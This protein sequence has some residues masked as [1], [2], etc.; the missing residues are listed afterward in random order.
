[1]DTE[2]SQP[3]ME[4][5][6]GIDVS[7]LHH[8]SNKNHLKQSKSV[9]KQPEQ[10]R[11]AP[12]PSQQ[13]KPLPEAN[14]QTDTGLQKEVL[15]TPSS[16]ATPIPTQ[17]E[18]RPQP[19]QKPPEK[20]PSLLGKSSFEKAARNSTS[21]QEGKSPPKR[22][23][24]I[25]SLKPKFGSST[26]VHNNSLPKPEP[27]TNGS[28]SEP[29]TPPA[30]TT[31]FSKTSS[32][33]SEGGEEPTESLEPYVPQQ[34]K[35]GSFLSSALRRLSSSGPSAPSKL[36]TTGTVCPRQLLNVDK[37]RERCKIKG[38]EQ[39][40]LRRV[41]FSVD[42]EIAGVS[43]YVED[44]DP[45]EMPK[46]AKDKRSSARA[47]G[48]ALKNPQ[49][50]AEKKDKISDQNEAGAQYQRKG[51]VDDMLEAEV[52]GASKQQDFDE[53]YR[54][55][56]EKQDKRR[57]QALANGSTDGTKVPTGPRDPQ[58]AKNEANSKSPSDA[59][60]RAASEATKNASKPTTDPVRVYRRCCQLRDAPV[61]KRVSEQ[62][63][64]IKPVEGE[65]EGV[66]PLL[67]L[68]GSRMQLPDF[69]VLGDWLAIVPVKKLYMD[70]ANLNDE[71]LRVILAGLLATK[72]PGLNKRKRGK[73]DT[74]GRQQSEKRRPTGYIEKLSFRNNLK[75]TPEAWKHMSL[76]LNLSHTVKGLDMS[77]NPFP[78]PADAKGGVESNTQAKDIAGMLSKA[79]STRVSDSHFEE[80]ILSE[81]GLTSTQIGPVIDGII[82]CGIHRLGF[83][84]N[85]LDRE[86]L[87]HVARYVKSRKVKG[88][89]LGSNDLREDYDLI[90]DAIESDNNM[91]ALGLADCNLDTRCLQS[92]LPRLVRLG[93]FRFLDL[94]HNHDLFASN[95]TALGVLRKYMPKLPALRRIHLVDVSL[96]PAD[97]IALAEVLPEVRNLTHIS[98]QGNPQ[99]KTLA[100]ATNATQQEDAVAY[101]ASLMAAV[102]VSKVLMAVDLD[103]PKQDS[104]DVVKALAKQIVAYSLRNMDR[105]TAVDAI[106]LEDPAS[107]IPD[108]T[109]SEQDVPIPDVLLHLVGQSDSDT[110]TVDDEGRVG[111]D[112]DYLIGGTGMVKALSY[113]LGQKA[114]DMRRMSTNLNTDTA[115]MMESAEGKAKAKDMSKNLLASARRMR[116]RLQSAM[117]REAAN[118]DEMAYRRLQFLDHTLQGMIQ[119]FEDE[120]PDCAQIQSTKSDAPPAT[121][122]EKLPSL[123]H[124]NAPSIQT[125]ALE[126]EPIEAPQS[127]AA[128]P[129][130]SSA[131][132]N[133]LHATTSKDPGSLPVTSPPSLASITAEEPYSTG[134]PRESELPPDPLT[135]PS[136]TRNLS[137]ATAAGDSSD[138]TP[139]RRQS[140]SS[141]AARAQAHEEGRMHR[142]GQQLRRDVLPPRGTDDHLHAT[143]RDDEPEGPRLAEL[144]RKLEELD[145]EEIR[146]KVLGQG[147]EATVTEFGLYEKEGW[148]REGGG[149]DGGNNGGGASNGLEGDKG[150]V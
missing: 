129:G 16:T 52:V 3:K 110:S 97:A 31:E 132:S 21:T 114:S 134:F 55:H 38:L 62:L 115:Q 78:Q 111:A 28:R 11:S 2:P 139:S 68:N 80:F 67:D 49:L 79:L 76:F 88:L 116:P 86:G 84:K 135:N 36:P 8:H 92:L 19:I 35:S 104:T 45:S 72:P 121:K 18:P 15:V 117:T 122:K 74:V 107:V 34:P 58:S 25:S 66:V 100:S 106:R 113:C 22:P 83:A 63:Q 125:P 96:T 54:R 75:L 127:V 98:F 48:E 51:S 40:K 118:E 89:D 90:A 73:S 102:R 109:H 136:A 32:A 12:S 93:D 6:H 120:F 26:S 133:P 140:A 17:S 50:L 124:H 147:L 37:D 44:Q 59:R 131:T 123:F 142:M 119:R 23:N 43:R 143:S 141:L 1:M 47:E 105:Y 9:P 27:A 56:Q 146:E 10:P 29:P 20:R 149:V 150:K 138:L 137:T 5:V 4:G 82:A 30:K 33:V 24:W 46:K 13:A 126:S 69:V 70:N 144:R 61:I 81:C 95:P 85:H 71:G 99:L 128:T 91:W 112:Q 145:G 41:A 60:P 103:V 64:A 57:Q 108:L 14:T 53:L 94:S 130:V 7:W 148:R 87:K 39:S 42:V 65:A 77:L 101:Y